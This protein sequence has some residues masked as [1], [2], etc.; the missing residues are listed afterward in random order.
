MTTSTQT[1]DYWLGVTAVVVWLAA[2]R[3]KG[4]R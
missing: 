3:W 1:R 2:E 4:E